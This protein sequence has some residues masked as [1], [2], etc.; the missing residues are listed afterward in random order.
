MKIILTET[1]QK[2]LSFNQMINRHSEKN[3]ELLVEY[4]KSRLPYLR[5]GFKS[6][7][8][9]RDNS[10]TINFQR[11]T[12]D[13]HDFMFRIGDDVVPAKF[14]SIVIEFNVLINSNKYNPHIVFTLK[15]NDNVVPDF[16][17][18]EH[19]NKEEKN[20]ALSTYAHLK[21]LNESKRLNFAKEYYGEDTIKNMNLTKEIVEPLNKNFFD[22]EQYFKD[23]YNYNFFE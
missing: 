14:G 7:V 22:L 16:D 15:V 19:W 9:I 1:Q 20:L 3:G 2:D 8:N 5:Y 21:Q 18:M 10:T 6:F 23:K 12:S 13:L 17:V 11:V 4:F